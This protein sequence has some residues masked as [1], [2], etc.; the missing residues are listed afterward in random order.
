MVRALPSAVPPKMYRHFALV[1]VL[2]TTA[3]A[4]F[5]EGENRE[6]RT[7]QVERREK[8]GVLRQ[9]TPAKAPKPTLARRTTQPHHR[10]VQEVRGFDVSFGRPMDHARGSL[11]AYTTQVASE[12]TQAGYSEAYLSTLRTEE[13]DLLLKGL[14]R[15]GLLSPEERERKSAALIA[16]SEARSGASSANY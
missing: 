14:S 15:E 2:L 9:D 6:A 11:A 10:F 1:T 4:M 7:T 8:P 5:A 12:V 3:V 13:R 16:A